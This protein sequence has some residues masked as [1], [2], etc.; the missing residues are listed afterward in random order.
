MEELMNIHPLTAIKK[1]KKF[2]RKPRFPAAP[3]SGI[4]LMCLKF[5]YETEIDQPV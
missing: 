3:H 2:N 4:S 1:E 5:T